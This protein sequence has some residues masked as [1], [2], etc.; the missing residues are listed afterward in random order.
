MRLFGNLI[1]ATIARMLCRNHLKTAK[2]KIKTSN[3]N[4][5]ELKPTLKL[6]Q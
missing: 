3:T 1:F 4:F 5:G 2:V 6:S